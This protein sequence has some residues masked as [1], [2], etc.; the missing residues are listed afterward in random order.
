MKINARSLGIQV[1]VTKRIKVNYKVVIVVTYSTSKGLYIKHSY[2]KVYLKH[3]QGENKEDS[4]GRGLK[5]KCDQLDSFK[6]VKQ[7]KLT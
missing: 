1:S 6:R 7:I 2:H 4:L 5:C 3:H